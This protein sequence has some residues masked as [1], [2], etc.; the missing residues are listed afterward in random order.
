MDVILVGGF[1]EVIELC[2]NCNL[3]I[4]GIIDSTSE[5]VLNGYPVI[6]NDNN[7]VKIFE[8]YST[9]KL[10]ITPDSPSIRKKLVSFYTQ[11]G[12]SFQSVISPKAEISKSSKLGTGVIIQSCVNISSKT[13]IGNFVKL[14]TNSN[15]MHECNVNDYVTV[16]PNVV[17]LGKVEIGI[18]SYIGAN[19]TILPNVIIHENVTV[20]AGAVVVKNVESSNTV[21][22][23]PAK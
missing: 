4:I 2:E 13:T 15:I 5:S 6:G 23:V 22:G 18:E 12:F 19:A 14:N 21:K 17:V 10:V 7:A 1:I 8:Q 11:I 3:N 9:A 16:A 20:G